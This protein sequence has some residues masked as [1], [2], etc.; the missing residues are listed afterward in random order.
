MNLPVT[1]SLPPYVSYRTFWNF[2]DGLKAA[3]PAR[4]DRSFWGDKFSGSTGGQLISALKY[5]KMIDAAGIPTL[6]LRQIVFAKGQQ[7]SD[8]LQQLAHEAYPFFLQ[9][10][11][12][13]T[14]T[15]SQLEEKLRENFPITADVNRKCIKFFI[16]MAD[17]A[18]ITLSSFITRKSRTSRATT[19][20]KVRKTTHHPP[21]DAD[22]NSQPQS[23]SPVS[24]QDGSTPDANQL[25]LAKFPTF[26]PN[27]TDEVK[28]R[29]FETFDKLQRIM[30]D[31]RK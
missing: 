15:Y 18:G 29:W 9:A 6:R 26:D 13:A 16:G 30:A 31:N 5:L 25:L 12:P 3:I 8:L 20:K 4:I 24:A 2:L 22:T 7:R 21:Q 14:A 10:L 28:L 11:D 1:K 19:A 17:E 23:L 27:W